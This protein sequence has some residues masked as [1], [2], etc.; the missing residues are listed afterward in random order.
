MNRN[1]IRIVASFSLSF[2]LFGH[3]KS[4]GLENL[5]RSKATKESQKSSNTTNNLL[6]NKDFQEELL[7]KCE[8]YT[9]LIGSG[10][11][12]DFIDESQVE[13]FTYSD[14]YAVA[15]QINYIYGKYEKILK[16]EFFNYGDIELVRVYAKHKNKEMKYLYYYDEDGRINDFNITI[17]PEGQYKGEE[18]IDLPSSKYSKDT[19][20]KVGKLALDGLISEPLE[21]IKNKKLVVL[22]VQGSGPNGMDAQIGKNPGNSVFRQLTEN[23][24]KNGFTTLRYNKSSYQLPEAIKSMSIEDEYINDVNDAVKLL[25][26]TFPDYKIVIA[27]HSQGAMLLPKFYEDNKD[28]LTA[29]I[30]LAGTSRSLWDIIFDQN[31]MSMDYTPSL[32]EEDKKR[33]IESLKGQIKALN[34]AKEGDEISFGNIDANYVISLNNLKLGEKYKKLDAPILLLQG[35]KDFQVT[36]KDFEKLKEDLKDNKNMKAVLIENMTHILMP[37][38]GKFLSYD[39]NDENKLDEKLVKEMVDFLD[40][41]IK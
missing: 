24:N 34:E 41:F 22:L 40:S 30:S 32:K 2:M 21:G 10:K 15:F 18:K 25:K 38:K 26:K 17:S 11:L 4:Y 39:Y 31:V 23:L 9:E 16:S 35:D 37:S 6:K 8:R 13:G 7:K 1:F 27:G 36:L 3:T 12:Q 29:L 20:V 14:L 5:N 28:D 33:A 19:K